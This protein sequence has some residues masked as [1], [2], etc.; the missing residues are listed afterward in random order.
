MRNLLL[1]L[2][3]F[4]AFPL[5]SQSIYKPS[6][7]F[8]E[9][10]FLFGGTNYSGDVAEKN[11]YLS[12]TQ[13]GYGAHARYFF[14]N[15]FAV[16]A[17]LFYGSISGDDANAKNT[18]LQ[19]RS[20]RFGTDIFELGLG[21]EWHVLGRDRFSNADR[22]HYFLSP[23]IYLGVGGTSSGAIAEYYGKP[24]DR[25]LFLVAPMP[26]VG[27]RQQFLI[28][29]MGVGIST[30]L[31]EGLVLGGE[32]GWRPVFSDNL[33]GVRLNGNPDNN[34]WYYYGGATLSFILNTQKKRRP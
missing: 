19:R 11:F 31:N 25:K 14:S 27:S 10:G 32:L 3:L 5:L 29:P 20:F 24:E 4:C 6:H 2:L 22:R 13:P 17:H 33:D 7:R 15:H 21:A 8:F 9:V 16:R 28:A 1:C 34:D 30:E 26:E 23:Y 12:E 18:A